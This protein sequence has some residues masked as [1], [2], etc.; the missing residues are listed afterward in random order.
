MSTSTTEQFVSPGRI[1]S[2][3]LNEGY[4]PGAW[5]GA[6]LKAALAD[7]T[8]DLAFWRVAPGRHNIAEIAL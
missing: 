7:V 3:V 2:R 4:G 8:P 5:H 6:D 1:H